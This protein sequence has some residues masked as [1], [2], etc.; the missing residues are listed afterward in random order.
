MKEEDEDSLEVSN[1]DRLK[2][3]YKIAIRWERDLAMF[4]EFAPDLMVVAN[5]DG[6][7][8]RLSRSWE[9]VLG[10]TRDE[11][12][13]VPFENFIVEEDIPETR[14]EI[15]LI[16]TKKPTERFRNR[17]QAKDGS[18]VCLE[19]HSAAHGSRIYGVARVIKDDK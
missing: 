19:W 1:L 6:Y 11:L 10:Y 15:S 18:I 14:H 16:K 13:A 9:K 5:K 3:L 7:F 8:I 17:Y 12:M 4:F 2:S